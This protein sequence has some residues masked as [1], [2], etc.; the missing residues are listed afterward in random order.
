LLAEE[1]CHFNTCKADLPEVYDALSALVTKGK[2][3]TDGL[4][5]QPADNKDWVK[6][7][8]EGRQ[9]AEDLIKKTP[10]YI[11][12]ISS[13]PF[14]RGIGISGS[15]SKFYATEQADVDYFIITQKDRLWISRTLLHLFKKLTF[16]TGHQHYYCMNYFVDE[17]ALEINNRNLYAAIETVT[18]IPVYGLETI[19]HFRK[20][21]EWIR[22][23]LP[24]H[25]NKL[26]TE[27]LVPE[28]KES[29]KALTESLLNSLT[30]KKLNKLFMRLTDRKW[31]RKWKGHGYSEEDYKRAFHTTIS[32]SKNHPADFEKKVMDI[33]VENQ[34]NNSGQ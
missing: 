2:V 7:R 29:F 19:K 21:N 6:E 13:F 33:M 26:I 12:R 5:Y 17:S 34:S 11:R 14:I 20:A 16:I 10:A 27:Y 30:P 18:I 23:Y 25:P 22:D 3:F 9:R 8:L 15:L 31:R 32:V 4:Y 28:K 1:V 24:N